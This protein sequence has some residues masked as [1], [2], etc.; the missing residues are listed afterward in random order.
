MT[1]KVGFIGLGNMGFNMA[2]NLIKKGKQLVVYDINEDAMNRLDQSS[3]VKATSPKDVADQS[4]VVMVSLP[5]PQVVKEVALGENG[6]VNGSVIKTYIDLSSSGVDVSQEVNE[7]MNQNDISVLDA[8]VSGGV[9]GAVNGTLTIMVAGNY[10]LYEEHKQLLEL[11]C[12]KA[13]YVDHK[14]GM[15]QV[16][17]VINNLLSSSAL[18]ITSEAI[19]LGVKAGL[20]PDV[21][22]DILNASS[23]R[24]SAT[25]DKFKKS[26]LNRKF[27]YGFADTLAY[28]DLKLCMELAENLQV[29]MLISNHIVNFWKFVVTQD[30]PGKDYTNVIRYIEEWAGVTVQSKDVKEMI[31]G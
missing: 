26:I 19:V 1:N 22:I 16:M 15:A 14:V 8:P 31:E 7:V 20:D 4:E 13:M 23:G 11:I 2:T 21:M 28:K 5:T 12:K 17:K 30:E 6:L 27:D 10:E 9:I 3:I 25:E 24:N 29:P 18:A